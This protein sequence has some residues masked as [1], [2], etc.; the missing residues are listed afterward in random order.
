MND[1]LINEYEVNHS[2][3][4]SY[5]GQDDIVFADYSLQNTGFITSSIDYEELKNIELNTFK[6]SRIDGGGVLSKYYRG[7]RIT[8]KGTIKAETAEAFH[9]LIDEV[10]KNIRFT[11]G[12]L[13]IRP[14]GSTEIRR[15]KATLTDLDLPRQHF[16]ITFCEITLVFTTAEPFFY[17]ITNQ[18][19]TFEAK[20]GN[21]TEDMTHDGSAEKSPRVYFV[22][23]VG[24]TATAMTITD[25]EGRVLTVTTALTNGDLLLVDGDNKVVELNGTEI[26]FSGSFPIFSPG[27]NNFTVGFTGTVLADVTFILQKNYL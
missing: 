1:F 19:S 10:K 20:T 23:G 9:T 13:D 8:I 3:A 21:F 14:I 12:N 2:D 6:Y 25:P 7:R 5:F 24:T 18:S 26:D 4:P 17:A 27:G 16:N 15:I 11:E 22:F